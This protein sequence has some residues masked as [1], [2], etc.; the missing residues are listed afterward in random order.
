MLNTTDDEHP[1]V[2]IKAGHDLELAKESA[3]E[4][5]KHLLCK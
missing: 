1:K 5:R 4:L 3:L 2:F